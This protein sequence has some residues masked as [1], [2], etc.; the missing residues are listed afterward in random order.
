MDSTIR[1]LVAEDLEVLREHFCRLIKNQPDLELVGQA[2]SGKEALAIVSEHAVDVILMDIEMEIKHDG[3]IAASRIL[4]QYPHIRIVFL[5]VH[6]DDE[7]VFGAFE[8][9]AVDYVLKTAAGSEIIKSIRM[10]QKGISPIR[11][12]IAYKIRNEFT[13]IRKNQANLFVVMSIVSQLTPSE[14][15]IIEL[16]LKDQKVQEIAKARQVELSTI[17]SQINVILK[18]FN[19]RRSKEVT[20]L[21]GELNVT[22]LFHR[23]KRGE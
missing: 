5:T 17:K 14:M 15:E 18:K 10:A 1:V 7:T 20:K 16:L 8:A 12:E 22:H 2:S 4:E 19:K 9:G 23:I 3:I 21:L 6:E 13:R 11:S